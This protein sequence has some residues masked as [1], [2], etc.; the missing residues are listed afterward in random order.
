MVA[1]RPKKPNSLHVLEG[2]A[3][4]DRGTDQLMQVPDK[5]AVEPELK[6]LKNINEEATFELLKDWVIAATGAAHIDSYLLSMMVEELKTYAAIS[7]ELESNPTDRFL[8]NSRNNALNNFHK[9]A[10][11]FGMTPQT[12]DM[13]V[14]KVEDEDPVKDILGGP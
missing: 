3:R 1:G 8:L 14:K 10:S 12:R 11:S 13:M 2:T 7:S 5:L 6:D 9:L 4:A